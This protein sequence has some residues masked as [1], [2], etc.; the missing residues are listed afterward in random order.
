MAK[1]GGGGGIHGEGACMA[2]GGMHGKGGH[3]C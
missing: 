1:G 3:A 2:K